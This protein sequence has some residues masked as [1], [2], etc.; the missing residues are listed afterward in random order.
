MSDELRYGFGKNWAEFIEK[1]LSDSIVRESVDHMRR[2]MK[3]DNLNGKTFLDIGCGS[4]IHS[5]AALRLGAEKV[6]AFDYD[7]HSVATSRKVREWAGVP[8]EKWAIQQG[9]VLDLDFMHSLPKSDIVYSWGVL[10]HTGS[11]WEA[12]RNATIPTKSDGEF[13]IALYSS[14]IYVDPTPEFWIKLKRA[15]NQ[16]D[17]MTRKL[18]EL[19]YVYWI[20]IKPELD[21]G[22]DPLD[23]M[24]TYGKR[25]MTAW[26]DAKDWM[27]GY[28]MEFASLTETRAFCKDVAGLDMVNVLTGEGCTEY[29]FA[30]T[31]KNTRW[32]AI[33]QKRKQTKLTGT[34][35]HAGG[36]GYAV[37]LPAHFKSSADDNSDH[38]RSKVMIFEDGAPLG[39]AH[40]MHDVIRNLGKG[41]FS[42]WGTGVM[43]STS[44]NSD[45]NKNGRKYTYCEQY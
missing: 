1:K 16:A 7:E 21:A 36:F 43:F 39:I 22:R 34:F 3:V 37:D 29:L 15:Y 5:L 28:P 10:H 40:S 35:H 9:S 19:K 4:G 13:Y 30:H 18:M 32:Q 17:P 41:R 12:V 26:T 8:V 23:L 45:P 27:G 25:G 44:D 6:V 38:M 42:H 31:N 20:L 24:K 11:M 14:D 2:F 33:E